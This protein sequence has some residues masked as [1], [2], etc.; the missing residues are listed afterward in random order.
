MAQSV[1]VCARS[2]AHLFCT[3]ARLCSDH[4]GVWLSCKQNSLR[5]MNNT[6]AVLECYRILLLQ[7]VKSMPHVFLVV[8]FR[9]LAESS[10]GE[11]Y[12]RSLRGCLPRK[13][14]VTAKGAQ[15]LI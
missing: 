8:P 7:Q 12:L 11:F 3:P 4:F 6:A 14:F 2:H 1:Q 9:L 10:K 5:A 15:F 13:F